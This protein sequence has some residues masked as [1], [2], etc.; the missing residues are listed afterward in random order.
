MINVLD[1]YTS[2]YI[3]QITIFDWTLSTSDHTTP[4][5]ELLVKSKSVTLRLAVSQSVSLGVE[6]HLRLMTR[7]LLLFESTSCFCGAPSLTRGRV[8][9]LVYGAGPRQRTLSQVRVPWDSW[10]YFT[11]S[12]SRLPQPGGPGHRIYI[13]QEQ[14][15]P[16]IPPGIRLRLHTDEWGSRQYSTL[17]SCG[18]LSELLVIVGF[19]LYRLG[20]DHSTEN[21]SIVYQWISSIVAYFC[22]HYL[23]TGCLL[24]M[25]L[26]GKVFIESLPS[27]GSLRHNILIRWNVYIFFGS[28]SL[29]SAC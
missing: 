2:C 3:S 17:Y 26:R 21:T 1:F 27:N 24:R 16:V 15:G 10:P 20:S 22:T 12:D 25:C 23:A 5:T 8:C 6:P 4:P 11:V 19:S 29:F 13:P 14:G 7:Y 9:L 28:L 18:T